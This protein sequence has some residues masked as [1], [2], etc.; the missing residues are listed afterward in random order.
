M[1]RLGRPTSNHP[2]ILKGTELILLHEAVH[3][4]ESKAWSNKLRV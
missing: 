4:A 2:G 1:R 3:H